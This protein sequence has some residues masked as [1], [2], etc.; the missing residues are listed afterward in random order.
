LI[1]YSSHNNK[2]RVR[3][4]ET[5]EK[6][7][8]AKDFL[9]KKREE[10]MEDENEQ[11]EDGLDSDEDYIDFNEDPND[12][13]QVDF[14]VSVPNF[15]KDYY[16]IELFLKNYLNGESFDF[17][18]LTELV[19]GDE[20]K[21][22]PNPLTSVIKVPYDEH[23]N[24][25]NTKEDTEVKTDNKS[26][27]D[28]TDDTP[29]E[30]EWDWSS[31][32]YGFVTCLEYK[33]NRKLDCMK[34]IKN[35]VISMAP[36]KMKQEITQI[37]EDGKIGIILNERVINMPLEFGPTLHE[38]LHNEI[39]EECKK[40]GIWFKYF[41]ILSKIYYQKNVDDTTT[42]QKKSKVEPI[43][44]KPEEAYYYNKAKLK[45]TFPLKYEYT[46]D[47]NAVGMEY[48]IQRLGVVMIF[49][50]KYEKVQKI[51]SKMKKDL[52]PANVNIQRPNNSNNN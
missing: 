38:N 45:F 8:N 34:Q 51:L 32:V 6:P 46:Y 43:F 40:N 49:E 1:F 31:D 2:K 48:N 13:L 12:E 33:K 26:S 22:E 11:D 35:Y 44:Q 27:D 21:D 41:F 24:N 17:V 9:E 3:K 39:H 37:F 23:N 50:S 5:D 47:A 30:G 18:K 25:N 42:Q 52:C 20:Q 4:E 7:T 19:L 14:D 10:P 16:G 36:E 15:E 28:M 29:L